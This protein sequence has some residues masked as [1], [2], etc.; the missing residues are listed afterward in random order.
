M[1]DIERGMSA[2]VLNLPEL[3][4]LTDT[5][6]QKIAL[7]KWVATECNVPVTILYPD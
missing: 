5:T 6:D 4:V 3:T 1:A 7:R 2:S